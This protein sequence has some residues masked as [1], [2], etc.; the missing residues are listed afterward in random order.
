MNRS[1]RPWGKQRT[2]RR[3]QG[4]LIPRGGHTQL[5]GREVEHWAL[6]PRENP[7]NRVLRHLTSEK[8]SEHR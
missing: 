6:W 5:R 4:P 7:L 1:Q 2:C 8:T 3:F